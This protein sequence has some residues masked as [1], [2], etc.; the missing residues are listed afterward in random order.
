MYLIEVV[1]LARLPR[2]LPDTFSYFSA[3]PISKGVVVEI[4]VKQRKLFGIV[5]SSQTVKE[6]KQELRPQ[7]LC[8]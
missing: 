3:T 4:E 8:E 1:P 2:L 7:R 6:S 5:L